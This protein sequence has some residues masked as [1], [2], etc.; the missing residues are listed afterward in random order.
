MSINET[1][2]EVSPEHAWGMA[3]FSLTTAATT[4]YEMSKSKDYH[5][6]AVKDL[7]TISEAALAINLAWSH[8]KRQ[9]LV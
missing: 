2:L 7:G 4:I 3:V 8:L 6:L 9:E 1:Q 5:D